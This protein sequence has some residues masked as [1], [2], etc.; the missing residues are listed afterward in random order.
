MLKGFPKLLKFVRINKFYI[1]GGNPYLVL[2][3]H[4]KSSLFTTFMN[5][6]DSIKCHQF[7]IRYARLVLEYSYL[8]KKRE[9]E[10]FIW[11]MN[12]SLSCCDQI[13]P[14]SFSKS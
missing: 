8:K 7:V 5:K 10:R 9:I 1:P 13:K 4:K 2:H 11:T 14:T 3:D 6:E 12:T